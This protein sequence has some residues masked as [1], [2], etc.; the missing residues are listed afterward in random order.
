MR[1]KDHLEAWF[2]TSRQ[3]FIVKFVS[4]I[5]LLKSFSAELKPF[6]YNP[7]CNFKFLSNHLPWRKGVKKWVPK[8]NWKWQQQVNPVSVICRLKNCWPWGKKG[9]QRTIS[10][11]IA[12]NDHFHQAPCKNVLFDCKNMFYKLWMAVLQFIIDQNI[13]KVTTHSMNSIFFFLLLSSRIR[14]LLSVN[15]LHSFVSLLSYRPFSFFRGD[16][17]LDLGPDSWRSME[18]LVCCSANYV[19]LSSITFLERGA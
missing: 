8:S 17:G 16:D 18:G 1:K 15:R 11:A 7:M 5:A 2:G 12:L 10:Y 13:F 3:A 14:L 4:L 19:P 9:N 6:T